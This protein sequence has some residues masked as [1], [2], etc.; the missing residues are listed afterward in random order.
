M[1][2]C[3]RCAQLLS[4][5]LDGPLSA[6]ETKELE[7]HLSQCP[8]CR[9]LASRLAA[10]RSAFSQLED[11]TAPESFTQGVMDRI[12]ATQ[13]EQNR[14]VPLFRRT[15]VQA[16]AGLAACALVCVGL[17]QSLSGLSGTKDLMLRSA[18]TPAGSVPLSSQS[19]GDLND[20]C[21]VETSSPDA[22][23]NGLSGQEGSPEAARKAGAAQYTGPGSADIA[24]AAMDAASMPEDNLYTAI[25]SM[26]SDGQN[27]NSSGEE[28]MLLSLGRLPEGW[29]EILGAEEPGFGQE[30]TAQ[31]EITRAQLDALVLLAQEQEIPLSLSGASD[32]EGPC[33]LTIA[34]EP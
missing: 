34:Q 8:A 14:P 33:V 12:R 31:W 21:A 5:R 4:D 2:D 32:P 28:G 11:L 7:E 13:A 29:E 6:Q 3:T 16:L 25:Y 23:D 24:P 22:T 15:R 27:T 1:T 20:R 30:E 10:T 19:A 17:Y 18:N 9:T 26:E